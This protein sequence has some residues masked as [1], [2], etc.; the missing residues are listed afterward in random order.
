M[1][2]EYD[3]GQDILPYESGAWLNEMGEVGWECYAVQPYTNNET[4][5]VYLYIKRKKR[6]W[7]KYT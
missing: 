4:E 3:L 7:V 5:Y 1:M 2:W 6:Q